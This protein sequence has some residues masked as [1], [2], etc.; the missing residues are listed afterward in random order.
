MVYCYLER[1]Q[2]LLNKWK[3][4]FITFCLIF[5]WG[6]NDRLVK[7]APVSFLEIHLLPTRVHPKIYV[8]ELI[9]GLNIND[10]YF[11][12]CP[13]QCYLSWV[14]PR[15]K[16]WVF[17]FITPHPLPNNDYIL[18]SQTP[19][20]LFLSQTQNILKMDVGVSLPVSLCVFKVASSWLSDTHYIWVCIHTYI[21]RNIHICM[22]ILLYHF[23]VS[24]LNIFQIYP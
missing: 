20:V 23:N 21:Q 16:I 5:V 18:F 15:Y 9:S 22:H 1:P 13:I 17:L 14:T 3:N 8:C 24:S 7:T 11:S 2:R 10:F 6:I 12:F 4:W 19:S